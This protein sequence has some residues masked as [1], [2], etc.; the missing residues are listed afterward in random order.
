MEDLICLLPSLYSWSGG[1]PQIRKGSFMSG[2]GAPSVPALQ[3]YRLPTY[4]PRAVYLAMY[5]LNS[6]VEHTIQLSPAAGAWLG[7]VSLGKGGSAVHSAG[8]LCAQQTDLREF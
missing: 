4:L 1:A 8:P 6:L 5:R 7:F 2:Q 3:S